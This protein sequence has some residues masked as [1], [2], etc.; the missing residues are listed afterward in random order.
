MKL[1]LPL[2]I[3]TASATS[4]F[5]S[6]Q[7]IATQFD[8]FDAIY[9][10]QLG[11]TRGCETPQKNVFR[12]CSDS[13]KNDGNAPFILHHNKVTEKVVVLFHGLSDS[14]FFFRSIAKAIHQQGHNVVVALMPGH[15]KKQADADMQDPQLSDRWRAHVSEVFEYAAGLGEQRYFGGFSTGGV[16]ATEYILQNPGKVK[17]LMLFSGALALDS[18]VESIAKIWGIQWV[19]KW[20]DGE[21]KT[22]GLNR[23]KYPGVASFS[24]IELT[25]VIFSVRELIE[26]G[27]PLNLP[28]FSAHSAADVTTPIQGVKDLMAANKGVNR[29]F[30][31]PLDVDVCHADVV[32]NQKQVSE[33]QFD[34]SKLEEIMPCMVPLANPQHVEMLTALR[35]FLATY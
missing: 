13:L 6:A 25:E 24:A 22:Q 7:S 28:I 3:L 26:Q 29:L 9:K 31:I 5:V 18:G 21:Y 20:L 14:P 34:A 12:V 2:L 1:F 27:A 8:Q 35:Q 15:G 23:Y 17:G 32:V 30:E 10:T 4:V 16:L 19:A 33:M 11:A